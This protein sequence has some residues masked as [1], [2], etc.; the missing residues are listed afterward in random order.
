MFSTYPGPSNSLLK[1]RA[2]ESQ[3]TV[4]DLM[5][6]HMTAGRADSAQAGGVSRTPLAEKKIELKLK[7]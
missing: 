2:E 5:R 7:F 1:L 6:A 4:Q 3:R